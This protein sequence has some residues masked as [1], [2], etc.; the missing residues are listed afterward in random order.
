MTRTTNASRLAHFSLALYPLN[1]TKSDPVV[2]CTG[3]GEQWHDY[4]QLKAPGFDGSQTIDLSDC[5][6]QVAAHAPAEIRC[7]VVG[8]ETIVKWSSTQQLTE[9]FTLIGKFRYA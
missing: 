5:W 2:T 9:Q 3:D 7:T 8:R 1:Q 4:Q 6:A